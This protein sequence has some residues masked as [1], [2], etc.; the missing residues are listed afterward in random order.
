MHPCEQ[1]C[2][3]MRKSLKLC[4]QEHTQDGLT[5]CGGKEDLLGCS[6]LTPEGVWSK[7]PT[8]DFGFPAIGMPM[9]FL[10]PQKLLFVPNGIEV[11]IQD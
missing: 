8:L 2:K 9:L 7:T 3:K 10:G 1:R 5:I 6:S 11:E 4:S